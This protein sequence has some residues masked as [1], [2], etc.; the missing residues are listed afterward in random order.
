MYHEIGSISSWRSFQLRQDAV[1]RRRIYDVTG[2]TIR[3]MQLGHLFN[4][5]QLQP[6]SNLLREKYRWA[7]GWVAE[8]VSLLIRCWPSFLP[9]YMPSQGVLSPSSEGKKMTTRVE[10]SGPSQYWSGFESK[11]GG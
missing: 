10:I 3:K 2:K 8:V 5:R 4:I 1:V 7:E 9:V 6:D 11:K